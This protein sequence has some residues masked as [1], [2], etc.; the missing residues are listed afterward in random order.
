MIAEQIDIVRKLV[1]EF[2]IEN[3]PYTGLMFQNLEER[4]HIITIGTSILC[5]KW[6]VGYQGGGFVQ[7]FVSNDLQESIGRA[8]GTSLKG[9]KFFGQLIYNIPMPVFK[10]NN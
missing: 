10:N 7:A 6:G 1:E 9:F 3:A 4:E 2:Y 5:T 8:D